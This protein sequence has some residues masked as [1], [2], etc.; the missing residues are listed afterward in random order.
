MRRQAC[1]VGVD[2]LRLEVFLLSEDHR[3][4]GEVVPYDNIISRAKLQA[5]QKDVVKGG[6]VKV[7]I[8]TLKAGMRK[9]G[10]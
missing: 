7:P 2:I 3:A 1:L 6:G 9:K 4:E 5:L 8:A 10:K